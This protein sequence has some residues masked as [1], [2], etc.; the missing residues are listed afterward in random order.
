[1]ARQTRHSDKSGKRLFSHRRLVADLVRLLGDPWVDDLDLDR[2]ERL[3]A[4]HVAGGLR[5][6]RADM[7]WWAPFKPGAGRPAGAG[8][9]F[10]IEYLCLQAPYWNCIFI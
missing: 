1:M 4:E 2:L 10:H 3:P 8:V 9:M 7:P 5:V 6:R